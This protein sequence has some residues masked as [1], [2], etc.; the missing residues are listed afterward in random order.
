MPWGQ[1]CRRTSAAA[2][3]VFVEVRQARGN[4]R[5]ILGQRATAQGPGGIRHGALRAKQGLCVVLSLGAALL[6]AASVPCCSCASEATDTTGA[7]ATTST[8]ISTTC[9]VGCAIF[10]ACPVPTK[11]ACL[12]GSPGRMGETLHVP[13]GSCDELDAALVDQLMA[14]CRE[15]CVCGPDMCYRDC[16][17]STTCGYAEEPCDA[18]DICAYPFMDPTDNSDDID[19]SCFPLDQ[20]CGG[21][22]QTVCAQGDFCEIAGLLCSE[23]SVGYPAQCTGYDDP[24]AYAEAGGY[25]WCRP[26]PTAEY[27]AQ[28]LP[29]PV[30]GCDG[31][32]YASDCE[33]QLA[34]VAYHSAGACDAGT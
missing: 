12:V 5:A 29:D 32:T 15:S 23:D 2:E 30:C 33:R 20:A 3:R 17:E 1:A 7:G 26:Q 19:P 24:C 16:M 31:V 13:L 18:G 25:G 14:D 8:S 6:G 22:D 21:P 10:V 9:H 34:G 28:V 27:C 4:D 11:I